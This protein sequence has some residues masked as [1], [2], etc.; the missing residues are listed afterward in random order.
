MEQQLISRNPWVPLPDVDACSPGDIIL[1]IAG[2]RLVLSRV[3]SA[4]GVDTW[5]EYIKAVDDVSPALRE[6]RELARATDS[7]AWFCH[8][9]HE[10]EEIPV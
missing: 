9:G 1:T 7:R 8:P 4:G 10:R 6:A 3:I 2:G 5:W